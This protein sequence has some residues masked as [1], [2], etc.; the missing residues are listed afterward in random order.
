MRPA[1]ATRGEQLALNTP[2]KEGKIK[3]SNRPVTSREYKLILNADRFKDRLEGSQTF[4]NL[5]EFL[6][7]KQGGQIHLRQDEEHGRRTWYLDTPSL[8][9]RRHHYVLRVR[10]E[11]GGKKWFKVTLKYRAPDRYLSASQDLSST[12]KAQHK[13]EEDILPPF[14]SKF[15]HSASIERKKAPKLGQVDQVVDLFPGLAGLGINAETPVGKVNTFEAHEIARWVDQLKFEEEPI[16]KACLSFWYLIGSKKELPRIV[17]FS[18]DYDLPDGAG[19]GRD[20][21]ESYPLPVVAGANR[22]FAA[23]QRQTDWVNF[24]ATTKTAYAYEAL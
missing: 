7:N 24:R 9:F 16:V 14:T 15:S 22:L 6:V 10:E 18:F 17:E 8:D 21:P 5:V 13:F 3:A 23:L 19:D 11:D 4:W 20:S 1:S 12:K 2:K